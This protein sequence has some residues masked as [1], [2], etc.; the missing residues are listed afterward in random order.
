MAVWQCVRV[1]SDS[2]CIVLGMC[3]EIAGV[4]GRMQLT[5]LDTVADRHFRRIT[6]RWA[7]RPAMWRKLLMSG[8]SDRAAPAREFDLQAV[9]LLAADV[10][11]VEQRERQRRGLVA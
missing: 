9:Q 3:R 4:T 2:A 6:P 10:M 5:E 1:D 11:R 8:A 7:D